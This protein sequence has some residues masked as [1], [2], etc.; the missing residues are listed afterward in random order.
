LS[1]Y[2]K[3]RERKRLPSLE[4]ITPFPPKLS[5]LNRASRK[6]PF[7]ACKQN[8]FEGRINPFII[9][10]S[11]LVKANVV[12]KKKKLHPFIGKEAAREGPVLQSIK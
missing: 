5:L 8:D 12:G 2:L 11:W 3:T 1:G 10:S 9:L 4:N 6:N 7:H